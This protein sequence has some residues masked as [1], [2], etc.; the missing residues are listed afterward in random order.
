MAIRHEWRGQ[1][2]RRGQRTHYKTLVV[3]SDGSRSVVPVGSAVLLKAP[4]GE[5]PYVALVQDLYE[6]PKGHMMM[7]TRWFYRVDDI[8]VRQRA[9]GMQ[10]SPRM[11]VLFGLFHNERPCARA[12]RHARPALPARRAGMMPF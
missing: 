6:T 9:R 5:K 11:A 4:P 8:P 1:G 10:V 3:R 2:E 12:P 7:T